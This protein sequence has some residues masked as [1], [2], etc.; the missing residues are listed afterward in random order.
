MLA[1][2]L[3][4]ICITSAE[5]RISVFLRRDMKFIPG[6]PG[7]PIFIYKILL[8]LYRRGVIHTVCSVQKT[9]INVSIRQFSNLLIPK[10]I[11]ILGMNISRWK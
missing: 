11:S 4:E 6:Y 10:S 7:Y 1:A 5:T 9:G 2:P 3:M 8:L